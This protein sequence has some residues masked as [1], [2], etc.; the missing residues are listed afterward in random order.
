MRG[1]TPLFSSFIICVLLLGLVLN[2]SF[3]SSS[4]SGQVPA[5]TVLKGIGRPGYV[6]SD[7]ITVINSNN[8][9]TFNSN[10]YAEKGNGS[11]GYNFEGLYSNIQYTI[12]NSTMSFETE[13]GSA[14]DGG[15]GNIGILNGE[16]NYAVYANVS[17]T[18]IPINI[19]NCTYFDESTSNVTYVGNLPTFTNTFTFHNIALQ[20][21]GHGSSSIT[22]TLTQVFIANWTMM[23]VKME[24]G[25]DFS[26]MSLYSPVTH[27]PISS[28]TPF[29][30]NLVYD[31]GASNYTESQIVGYGVFLQ[32]TVTRTGIYYSA[33]NGSTLSYSVANMTFGD[34]FT[35]VR[36]SSVVNGTTE[37]YFEPMQGVQ[38]NSEP[39]SS[40]ATTRSIT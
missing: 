12:R 15:V 30:F 10:W 34:S 16:N 40:Y 14:T 36:G 18:I 28:G 19:W 33:G 25:V 27:Q 3:A 37:V 8:P 9:Q 6:L 35:D 39:T 7:G 1:P 20:T 38:G 2:A 4:Q 23:K 31:V 11:F 22:L 5:P 13:F 29:S 26:N 17:G 21:Y 32:P 24:T